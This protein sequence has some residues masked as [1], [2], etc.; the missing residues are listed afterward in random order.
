M[1][2]CGPLRAFALVSELI[3]EIRILVYGFMA[4]GKIHR[5]DS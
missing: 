2:E 1:A 3:L 5:N 4:E